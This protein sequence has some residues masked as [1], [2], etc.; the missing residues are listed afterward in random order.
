ML[1]A[2][3]K[4]PEDDPPLDVVAA[5]YSDRTAG[6]CSQPVWYVSVGSVSLLLIPT[7]GTPVVHAGKDWGMDAEFE[8]ASQQVQHGYLTMLAVDSLLAFMNSMEKLADVAVDQG[9]M[10][11]VAMSVGGAGSGALAFG[12]AGLD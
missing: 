11:P 4:D 8:M 1:K 7:P 6:A 5:L 3:N 10:V 9:G 2:S 12:H